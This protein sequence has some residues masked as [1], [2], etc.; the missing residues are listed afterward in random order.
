MLNTNQIIDL[1]EKILERFQDDFEGILSNLNAN[2]KLET[3]LELLDMSDL[4]KSDLC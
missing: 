4:L 1:E 2:G 3:L